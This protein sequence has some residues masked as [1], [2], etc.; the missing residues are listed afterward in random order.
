MVLYQ[1]PS[2]NRCKQRQ[3]VHHIPKYSVHLSV[4]CCTPCLKKLC[5]LVF[6]CVIKYESIS[7]KIGRHVSEETTNK[8]VRKVP[9]SPIMC[10]ST[11]LGHLKWQIE[12]STQYLYMYILMNYW[13]ATKP[14]AVIVTKIVERV[15]SGI[16]FISYDRNVCLQHERK[17]V[18]TGAMTPSARSMNAWFRL[19]TRFWCVFAISRHLSRTLPACNVKMM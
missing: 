9:T 12:P 17:N 8:T 11:T 18:D 7:I 14:L 15:V 13:T 3:C 6:C 16:I 10:A 2:R 5:Q 19:F 1:K 4:M